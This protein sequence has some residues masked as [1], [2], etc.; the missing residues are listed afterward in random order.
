MSPTGYPNS[1]DNSTTLPLAIDNITPVKAVVVNQLQQAILAI[2]QELGINPSGSFT[3]TGGVSGRLNNVDTEISTL[4]TSVANVVSE[5]EAIIA[6]LTGEDLDLG[7]PDG[8]FLAGITTLTAA[9]PITEAINTFNSIMYS[10]APEQPQSMNG[11]AIDPVTSLP[12]F[13]GKISTVTSAPST[14]YGPFTA[15]SSSSRITTTQSFTLTSHNTGDSTTGFS[16]ADKGILNV[17]VN[18]V[19]VTSFNLGSAFDQTERANSSGQGVTYDGD[20]GSASPPLKTVGN[21]QIYSV[22]LFNNF[23]LWQKGVARIIVSALTSG[24]NTFQFVQVIGSDTRTSELFQLFYDSASTT[25]TFISGPSLSNVAPSHFNILSGIKFLTTGETLILSTTISNAFANTYLQTPIATTFSAGISAGTI[26]LSD[27][28]VTVTSGN[29]S[30]PNVTDH[31]IVTSKTYPITLTG[32]QSIN[33][34]INVSYSNVYGTIFSAPSPS[35]N[36]LINTHNTPTST[37]STEAFLDENYRLLP[38]I[39]GSTTSTALYPNDYVTLPGTITGQFTSDAA[40]INGNAQVYNAALIYPT[41]NFT[42]GYLP[43][44]GTAPATGTPNYSGFNNTNAHN[45]QVYYRAMYSAGNPRS[46]GTLTIAGIDL[47]DLTQVSPNLKVEMKL[48]G[49]TGWLDFSKP[50][51]SGT[52]SGITGDGCRTGNSGNQFEWSIGSFTTASSGFFYILRITL[53]NTTRP[54]TALSEAF[55]ETF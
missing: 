33:Q 39:S 7:T 29:P 15:G 43:A 17:L 32:Q 38:D 47:L 50:F 16:D 26:D 14:Y 19:Q 23:P 51:N 37:A 22:A 28:T 4:T 54:I 36:L 40:L 18:G 52:F 5:V 55:T 25:P 42:S 11:L 49:I 30:A 1:I 35:Q 8:G 21:T 24:Y 20:T 3:I 31:L 41:I 44:Q 48:A 9:T 45:G 6:E 34:V 46:T 10:L 13:T 2:E 12:V 27:P 53:F